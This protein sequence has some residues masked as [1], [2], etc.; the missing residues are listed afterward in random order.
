MA[1]NDGKKLIEFDFPKLKIGS[2]E[3]EIGP[4]GVTT[5]YFPEKAIGAADVR[6][7]A[8]GTYNTEWLK[9]GYDFRNLDAITIG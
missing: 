6:G 8:P 3:N 5:F 1:I 7:G 9:L 4:T 2:V